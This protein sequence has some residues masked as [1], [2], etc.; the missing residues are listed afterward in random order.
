M[1]N[2]FLYPTRN[3]ISYQIVSRCVPLLERTVN[4]NVEEVY[5]KLKLLLFEKGCK[6]YSE[7]QLRQIYF[8]QGSLW[9]ISPKTAKKTIK[10]NFASV[11][12]G[13]LLRCSSMLTSDW[14]SITLIGC[15][16]ALVLVGLCLWMATDLST[17]MVTNTPGFWSWLFIFGNKVNLVA[18]QTFVNLTWGLTIFLSIIIL[19]EIFVVFYVYQKIDAVIEETLDQ[20]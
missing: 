14:K 19:L 17:F 8:K 11:D 1:K 2:Y 12:N 13:T 20:L 4:L 6:V 10:V 15:S 7:E 9:G 3:N 18:V 5:S 16:L